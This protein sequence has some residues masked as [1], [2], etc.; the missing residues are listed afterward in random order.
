MKDVLV[1]LF[2]PHRGIITEDN[3]ISFILVS[4]AS[5]LA[6]NA[7][8][9]EYGFVIFIPK[10][11]NIFCIFKLT[12]SSVLH[13]GFRLAVEPKVQHVFI[14]WKKQSVSGRTELKRN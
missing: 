12:V 7:N 8:F 4:R 9:K 14:G 11:K 13:N 5:H 3:F 6:G 1:L 10:F 2:L